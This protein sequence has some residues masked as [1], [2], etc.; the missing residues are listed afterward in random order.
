MNARQR[1][2]SGL[3]LAIVLIPVLAGLLACLPVPIGDP[4]RSR[5]DPD[6][7]GVW[8]GFEGAVTYF[9]PYD[10][11]TWLVTS[12]GINLP[13]GC[14]WAGETFEYEEFVA[15]FAEQQ[16]A[17]A[18]KATIFKAWRSKHGGHWFLTMQPMAMVD[19]DAEDPFADDVWFVYRIDKTGAGAFELL[20]I[21][22]DFA[23]FNDLPE[24]RRDYEKVIR[25]N[26]ADDGMYMGGADRFVRIQPEHIEIFAEFVEK[27]IDID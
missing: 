2:L 12:V 21:D 27:H 25:K 3:L 9:E 1:S 17:T 16:C 11:R 13:S 26:A 22:P 18:E 14:R 8:L 7:T 20:M 10:K 4:E 5:I 15:W 23:M 19:D 6:M 24:K